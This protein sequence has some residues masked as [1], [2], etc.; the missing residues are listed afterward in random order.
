MVHAI[1]LSRSLRYCATVAGFS[2]AI[3]ATPPACADYGDAVF[4]VG[5]ATLVDHAGRSRILMK[6]MQV[7]S[8]DL[9]RTEPGARVQLRFADG[10]F[11]SMLPDSEL[12]IDAY[13]YGGDAAGRE[14]AFFT[15]HRGGARFLTGLIGKARGSRFHAT[16]SV[17]GLD[18]ESG[19]F[20]AIVGKGLQVSVGTGQVNL[21]NERGMLNVHAGQ[22]AFVAD[23]A[24]APYL[25]GT[26]IPNRIAP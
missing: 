18:V 9:I 10:A 11:V 20:V 3:T 2:V 19:Q 22:R 25:V 7:H 12:G 4:V 8:G 1:S 6:G 16:T 13:R 24:T 17:A 14:T 5:R 21:R 26:T 23:R 15:L